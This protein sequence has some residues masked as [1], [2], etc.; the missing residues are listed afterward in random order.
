[1]SKI[2]LIMPVIP[3]GTQFP[4]LGCAVAAFPG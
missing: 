4:V 3:A 1:M 2:S